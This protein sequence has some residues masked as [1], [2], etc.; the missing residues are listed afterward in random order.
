MSLLNYLN[1]EQ[2]FLTKAELID[3]V[4]INL[5]SKE[6]QEKYKNFK[7]SVKYLTMAKAPIYQSK[8][9]DED[10]KVLKDAILYKECSYSSMDKYFL[11]D[12]TL[13]VLIHYEKLSYTLNNY[14]YE[15]ID[16]IDYK[17]LLNFAK[18]QL[19]NLTIYSSS[20]IINEYIDFI[21]KK[22]Q[23]LIQENYSYI[24]EQGKK[25]VEDLEKLDKTITNEL[26]V[27]YVY[28]QPLEK[29]GITYIKNFDSVFYNQQDK[30]DFFMIKYLRDKDYIS[31]LV[32]E[33]FYKSLQEKNRNKYTEERFY[34]S[35]RK[36]ELYNELRQS[37][38]VDKKLKLY[39]AI[40]EAT[41]LAGKTITVNG[42]KYDNNI[43][44][45][46]N[47]DHIEI[48][49]YDSIK[50]EDVKTITFGRKVLFDINNY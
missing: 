39:R 25:H 12:K 9:F 38:E 18:K 50:F 3:L 1:N 35:E 8:V 31:Q 28:D 6:E 26:K 37:F 36:K 21:N 4:D 2:D 47:V 43:L 29:L 45:S 17:Y 16:K 46:L 44:K 23:E 22:E 33:E 20:D 27:S 11:F 34:K 42:N 48:G 19:E 7:A 14:F 24:Y 41:K 49:H 32:E 5:L 15:I 10:D 13:N 30:H 40:Y